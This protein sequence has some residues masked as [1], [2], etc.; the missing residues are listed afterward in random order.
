MSCVLI[1]PED[2][3][4]LFGINKKEEG[5]AESLIEDRHKKLYQC[6][7]D[8]NGPLYVEGL[9]DAVLA[10]Y[11]DCNH[12]TLN[13]NKNLET[14]R[15]RYGPS[16]NTITSN[17]L[18]SND[19]TLIQIIGR[20]AFGEV[21]LVRMKETKKIYAMKI[22]NKF[23]M[24]RRSD[25]AF[26]W[27]E[28]DI[29]AY[30]KSDW[31]VQ[32]HYSF[33]DDKNLYMVMDYMPGGNMVSLMERYEI[34]EPWAKFYIAELVLAL[35]AVHKMGYI[36]RDV[37]P[38]NM[39]MD[40]KGHLKLADFGT[41]MKMDKSGKVHCETAVGT[42]D[43]IS[44]EVLKSQGGEGCYGVECDWWSVGVVT[45][46]ML[47]Q[48]LPFFSESLMG[49]YSNIMNHKNTLQFKGDPTI[50]V[51]AKR[52]ITQF[53]EDS[54][55]RLGMNGIAEIKKHAFFRTDQWTWDNISS[56]VPPVQ[57]ELTSEIDTQNFDPIEDPAPEQQSF[58]PPMEFQGNHLPFVGFTY[59]KDMSILKYDG[60]GI[61]NPDSSVTSEL[62][63]EI[64]RVEK[65]RKEIERNCIMFENKLQVAEKEVV[66]TSKAL[67][68]MTQQY[69]EV[70][71]DL[72]ISMID[73]KEAKRKYD[74][75]EETNNMLESQ[76]T[77]LQAKLDGMEAVESPTKLLSEIEQLRTQLKAEA[78]TTSILKETSRKLKKD[79]TVQQSVVSRLEDRCKTV[80][81]EKESL[82]TKYEDLHSKLKKSRSELEI[83][84]VELSKQLQEQEGSL[85]SVDSRLSESVEENQR[86]RRS[87]AEVEK[88]KTSL[89]MS[90]KTLQQRYDVLNKNHEQLVQ[91][92]KEEKHRTS[93]NKEE[94]DDILSQ[95]REESSSRTKAEDKIESLEQEYSILELD[96]KQRDGELSSLKSL[97]KELETKY[98]SESKR[99]TT[100]EKE[101]KK[102]EEKLQNQLSSKEQELK[103][104]LTEMRTE[105]QKMEDTIYRLKSENKA[106]DVSLKETREEL[107]EEQKE[108]NILRGRISDLENRPGGDV[109][110]KENIR[111]K[112]E[113][114]EINKKLTHALQAKAAAESKLADFEKEKMMIELDVKETIARHKTDVTERMAWAAKIKD[115]LIVV[116][117]KLAQRNL[118]NEQLQDNLKR[119]LL[120]LDAV[121]QTEG[122][123][124]EELRRLHQS[125][126]TERILKKEAVNKLTQVMFQRQPQKGGSQRPEPRRA[127]EREIRKLKG[128]LQQES[129]KYKR[130]VEKYHQQLEEVQ[131]QIVEETQMRLDLQH[132]LQQSETKLRTLQQ[133]I[134][135]GN[136]V[137]NGPSIEPDGASCNI[138]PIQER[139]TLHMMVP[140][141]IDARKKGWRDIFVVLSY[142]SKKLILYDKEEDMGTEA[143]PYIMLEFGQIY[144]VRTL[145]QGEHE[146]VRV[147]PND[148]KRVLQLA[149]EEGGPSMKLNNPEEFEGVV[150]VRGHHFVEARNS[151]RSSCDVCG[152]TLPLAL[153]SGGIYE[154]KS[155]QMKCHKDDIDKVDL[156]QPCVTGEQ[157]QKKLL[158]YV[159]GD[160]DRKYWLSKL[161]AITVSTLS[162]STSPSLVVPPGKHRE[163]GG[164]MRFSNKRPGSA[165]PKSTPSGG[166]TRTYSTSQPKRQ[167]SR[168]DST[169]N[170]KHLELVRSMDTDNARSQ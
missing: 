58:P 11:N 72:G 47:M 9:L 107:E 40:S 99:H 158:L 4:I 21:Q 160:N 109:N 79:L 135:S 8:N 6:L 34:P 57:P 165:Q 27:E 113:L 37:K 26:F 39:L 24:I 78:Q 22:L 13:R 100:I 17:R 1:L 144:S 28:R 131:R 36:H 41:C 81:S 23:E 133:G 85:A 89:E 101:L 56:C 53:L 46:E 83:K 119:A 66:D 70:T 168:N 88:H 137:S 68:Q 111:L 147:K 50:S 130:V 30:T 143:T 73:V 128:E 31:I 116:E 94:Y 5:M 138:S 20:G 150:H 33:Q 64:A 25:T 163:R 54:D 35:D 16:I 67:S 112:S 2:R 62:Q 10:V 126:E 167:H 118:E 124:E 76:V 162:R 136:Y 106:V 74:E 154:C 63:Q 169:G 110:E 123:Q 59:Q 93:S 152:K 15:K 166:P 42:P 157:D 108:S 38:E 3:I 51:A 69:N 43:Y 87:Y 148:A 114:S 122:S 44:P 92:M 151:S 127:H 86:L 155:C 55:L 71:K 141:G 156:I 19:F 14:F 140:K 97:I 52:I 96:L 134:G 98:Q 164:S 29:M 125:L 45:Y 91:K 142:V 104:Q 102:Q 82:E 48:D 84:N 161:S 139:E 77:T 129:Q 117:N 146:R 12:P 145:E 159:K 60:S 18:S 120:R 90:Y 75:L 115:Q 7:R 80:S 95:L 170:N 153:I 121:Q 132:Q 61:D 32:L 49:T 103:K 149:Y 105:K 65:A